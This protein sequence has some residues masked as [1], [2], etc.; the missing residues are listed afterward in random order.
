MQIQCTFILSNSYF[1]LQ[2]KGDVEDTDSE[3]NPIFQVNLAD[4]SKFQALP[5][6]R[7]DLKLK[8]NDLDNPRAITREHALFLRAKERHQSRTLLRLSSASREIDTIETVRNESKTK[9]K[10]NHANLER[11]TNL[12]Q[13]ATGVGIPKSKMVQQ[14]DIQTRGGTSGGRKKK[15]K[16]TRFQRGIGRGKVAQK[17]DHPTPEVVNTDVQNLTHPVTSLLSSRRSSI[18]ATIDISD[19]GGHLER[20][21]LIDSVSFR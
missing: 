5:P 6:L 11:S 17:D 7:H 13:T 4:H 20:S 12:D 21:V 16:K 1:F 18:A 10:L 19:N 14:D 2:V 9:K 15:G 8:T 3:I